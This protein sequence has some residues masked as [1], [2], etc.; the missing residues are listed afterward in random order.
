MPP[1]C[2]TAIDDDGGQAPAIGASKIGKPRPNRSQ[3]AAVR[4]RAPSDFM[5]GIYSCSLI[6][7]ANV[8]P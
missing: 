3:K 1:A 5:D 4:T 7:S 8:F 6:V 2:I